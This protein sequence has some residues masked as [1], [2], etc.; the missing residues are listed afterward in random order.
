[1]DK[2]KLYFEDCR[3]TRREIG[4][5]DTEKEIMKQINAFLDAHNYK[6]YYTRTWIDENDPH[7]KIYD[8]GSHAEFFICYNCAPGGWN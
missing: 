6:S 3:G 4:S 1:M 2:L 5:G 7:A 8:V